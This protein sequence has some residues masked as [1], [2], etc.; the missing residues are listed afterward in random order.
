MDIFNFLGLK[1]KTVKRIWLGA[2]KDASETIISSTGDAMSA[3]S[4]PADNSFMKERKRSTKNG[5]Y[6]TNLNNPGF[7]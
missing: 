5:F 6:C 1:D 7:I 2:S 4:G 3:L